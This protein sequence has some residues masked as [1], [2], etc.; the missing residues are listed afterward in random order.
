MIPKQLRNRSY[1]SDLDLGFLFR[2]FTVAIHYS[3]SVLRSYIS[4]LD[5]GFLFRLFTVVIH[6]SVSVF[7]SSKIYSL[8]WRA[9]Y[10]RLTD[11]IPKF[12][13]N[14]YKLSFGDW[15]TIR[16]AILNCPGYSWHGSYVLIVLSHKNIEF[17]NLFVNSN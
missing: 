9:L 12:S 2:L 4:H 3:V 17:E 10:W 13:E 14:F 15:Q 6:Y 7:R 11:N 16:L 8:N 5:L 1:I